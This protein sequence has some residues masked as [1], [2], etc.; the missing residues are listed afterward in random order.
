IS[1]ALDEDLVL[2]RLLEALAPLV[3][4][5]SA[6]V[7]LSERPEALHLRA[8]AGRPLRAELAERARWT[9]TALGRSLVTA[10]ERGDP[11]GTLTAEE[12]GEAALAVPLCSRGQALGLL[13]LLRAATGPFT[14]E[15]RRLVELVASVAGVALENARL[16]QETQRLATVDPL[17][18]V[19]NY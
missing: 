5:D 11:A 9:S 17:T 14:A 6:A 1:A 4:S 19:Y 3:A 7:Y 18:E 16:Y 15:E 2:E 12:R 8:S 10:L 13:L